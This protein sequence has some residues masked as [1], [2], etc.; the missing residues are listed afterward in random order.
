MSFQL[1]PLL[2]SRLVRLG[3]LFAAA[4]A[5]AGCGGSVVD[6]FE[7]ARIVSL[8]DEYSH[9]SPQGR[10]YTVNKAGDC[11]ANR[12][13]NQQLV[14]SY[15]FSF[16]ECNPGGRTGSRLAVLKAA[17][18]ARTADIA[19]Q[20]DA[21]A[22]LGSTDMVLLLVG[23]NDI[24]DAF[25]SGAS[26]EADVDAAAAR[27][28]AQVRRLVDL[29]SKVL[30]LTVPDQGRTPAARALDAS[31]AGSSARLTALTERFNT[32]MRNLLNEPGSPTASGRNV[33]LVLAQGVV[34]EVQ[35]N[36]NT[37]GIGNVD[38]GACPASAQGL[39]CEDTVADGS[40]GRFLYADDRY[41]STYA[42]S[43]IA[44]EAETRARNNPF[45]N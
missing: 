43:R 18:E 35:N 31:S 8:G 12:I 25:R 39:A 19:A 5:I 21:V 24:W 7:P 33:G 45:S 44:S 1:S 28:H 15:G 9:L 20:I 6:R 27:V 30:V 4:A 38:R 26:A 32:R 10:K 22:N 37:Y 29:R 2:R 40:Y 16:P 23:A 14:E 41:L 13:W 42:N 11:N 36:P 17:P 3:G 34:L